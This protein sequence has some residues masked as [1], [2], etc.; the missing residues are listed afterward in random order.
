MACGVPSV[1]SD[2]GS[3]PEV[4]GDAALVVP[5]GDESAL[6]GAL[7]RAWSDSDERGRLGA[8]G[9]AQAARFD[10][11]TTAAVVEN[12]YLRADARGRPARRQ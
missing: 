2:G 3:L 8:E 12:A 4:A 10:W 6:V 9:P 1:V 5:V 7:R 11:D